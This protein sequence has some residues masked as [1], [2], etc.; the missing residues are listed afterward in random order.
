MRN[1]SYIMQTVR[2]NA[3]HEDHYCQ[4]VGIKISEKLSWVEARIL[5][6][7]WVSISTLC[8]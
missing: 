8:C 2:H 3:Y 7:P 4:G 6:A 1:G 5:C